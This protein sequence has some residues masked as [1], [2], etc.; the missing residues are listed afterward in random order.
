MSGFYEGFEKKAFVGLLGRGAAAAGKLL[1]GLPA[2]TGRIGKF[3]A[4]NSVKTGVAV[5]GASDVASAARK[6]S[7]GVRM[8]NQ[9]SG[10]R[11]V[12][13]KTTPTF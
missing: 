9:L 4:K 13:P 7:S 10:L 6:A 3:V 8:R 5:L 2:R 11:A 12:A 1:G